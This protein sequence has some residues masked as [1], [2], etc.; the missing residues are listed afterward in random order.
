MIKTIIIILLILF[1]I[2]NF[3][4]VLFIDRDRYKKMDELG[5]YHIYNYYERSEAKLQHGYDSY[6]D[7][8]YAQD[9]LAKTLDFLN[10][11]RESIEQEN[12]DE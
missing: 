4:A 7:S 1:I 5:I 12:S 11:L 6:L 3:P 9:N 2:Y 8:E 10:G